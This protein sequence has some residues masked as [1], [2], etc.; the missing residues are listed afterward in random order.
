MYSDF[1]FFLPFNF[2]NW[3]IIALQNFVIFCQISTRISEACILKDTQERSPQYGSPSSPSYNHLL[4]NENSQF[5][6]IISL[7]ISL[8]VQW[9]DSTLPLQGTQIWSLFR[10][11]RS[12]SCAA[13]AAAK[14]LQSC[15]TLCDPIDGSPPGSPVPGILQTKILE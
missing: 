6:M 9:L 3:R 11:L 7:E 13:A 15:L 10:E 2:F 12:Y 14:S 8:V 5:C 1:F 4:V